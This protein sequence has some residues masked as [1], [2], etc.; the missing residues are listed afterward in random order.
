MFLLHYETIE[1]STRKT[2]LCDRLCET[3]QYL[4]VSSVECFKHLPIRLFQAIDF[5]GYQIRHYV[6]VR[7]PPQILIVCPSS[8]LTS[9]ILPILKLP[10]TRPYMVAERHALTN[11][12][13]L[14]FRK[15]LCMLL[16]TLLV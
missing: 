14:H 7:V 8:S 15:T 4:H 3:R 11:V 10:L 12:L 2:F 16:S 5:T 1:I 9:G 13:P 6:V